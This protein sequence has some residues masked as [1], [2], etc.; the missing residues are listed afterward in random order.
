MEFIIDAN[1]TD[2]ALNDMVRAAETQLTDYRKSI[3]Q[4]E[5]IRDMAKLKLLS[6]EIEAAERE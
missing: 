2:E 6:R 5:Q 3:A 1:A 4:L